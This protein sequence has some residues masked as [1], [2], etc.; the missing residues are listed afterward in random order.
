MLDAIL[1]IQ[2]FTAGL[3]LET[4]SQDRKTTRAVAFD[5]VILGE[6]LRHIPAEVRSRNPQIPWANIRGMRNVI[7]HDYGS[8][9]P[10]IVWKTIHSNL[11]PLVPILRHLLESEAN[12]Q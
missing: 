4:F 3:N 6:A 1:E 9:D 2:S 10:E 11:P 8:F 7:A 5:F 12:N